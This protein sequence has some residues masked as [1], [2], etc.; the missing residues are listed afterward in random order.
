MLFHLISDLIA[1]ELPPSSPLHRDQMTIFIVPRF[2]KGIRQDD[3]VD[4]LHLRI[5]RK[6]I[7]Q[8]EKH[9][10]INLSSLVWS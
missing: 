6:V 8:K 9:R 1:H 4:S 5:I 7:I 2:E 10:H 3:T